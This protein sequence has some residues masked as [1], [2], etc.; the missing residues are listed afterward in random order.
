MNLFVKIERVTN[1]TEW[2]NGINSGEVKSAYIPC[3]K[4]QSLNCLAS[5]HNQGRGKQRNKFVHYHYC[6]DLEVATIVCETR[7]DYL[8]NKENGEQNSRKAQIPKDFR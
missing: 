2:V 7:K 5:R 1:I 3:E 6:S 4:V 8:K